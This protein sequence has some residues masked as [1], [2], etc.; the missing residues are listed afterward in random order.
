VLFSLISDPIALLAIQLLDVVTGA[1]LAVMTP[2]IVADV[3]EG[4][5]RFNLAQ[6]MFG[7]VMG[8]GASISPTLTG[9]IVDRFGRSVGFAAI[10]REGLVALFILG[11]F[12]PETKK[13]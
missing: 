9:L 2:A 6:G 12:L 7:T 5:G 4:T 8:I 3:T 1:V 10:A 11:F 13:R